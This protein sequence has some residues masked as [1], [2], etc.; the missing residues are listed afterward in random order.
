MIAV[1]INDRDAR[2][3]AVAERIDRAVTMVFREVDVQSANV[4]VAIVDDATIWRLNREYLEHDYPT[5]VL[6]FVLSQ[7]DQRLEGEIIVSADTA[8]REAVEHGWSSE[9]ELLLYV[10]HGALHLVG[11]DDDSDENRQRMRE[12]EQEILS[13]L[14]D[15]QFSGD[16]SNAR[17]LAKGG[18]QS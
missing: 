11:Y 1:E 2:A 3:T 5:D 17:L 13:R 7:D 14:S 9:S 6:S 16:T 12:R 15:S 10:V 18:S 4:S 8:E